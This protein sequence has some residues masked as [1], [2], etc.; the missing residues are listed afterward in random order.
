MNIRESLEERE[1]KILSPF[2]SHSR[3]S[4]GRDRPEEECDI[5]TVY[6]RDRDRILHSKSFRR[7]KDKTQVFLAPQGDH[8]R[9]RLTHTLEVSQTART[10]AKALRLNEDLVEAIALGHDLGHTPFGHAGEHALNK[11]SREGFAHNEQSVRVV[12]VLENGSRGRQGLNLTWEVRD[13]ILNH[14]TSGTPHTLEGQIVRLCDK[15]SYIHHDMDDAQRA[16]MLTEDDIPITL[17][18]VLGYTTK[19]RLNTLIHDIVESSVDKD[20]ICMSADIEEAM[21]DLRTIMFQNVYRNPVAKKEEKKATDMLI[22]LFHYYM[23]HPEEMSREYREL[24]VSRGAPV[25]RVACDYISGMTDQ[26]SMDKFNQIFVP[27]CWSV[28]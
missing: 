5:R 6:Q 25:E 20:A 26:Y 27:K 18:M 13:G 24:I 2:A 1:M 10:I 7:L 3:D 16:G 21:M 8:Y 11:V 14:R 23:E 4:K 12:E 19:E 15:I 9:N 28:Y 22:G 17:R